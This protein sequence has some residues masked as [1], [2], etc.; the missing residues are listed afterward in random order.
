MAEV[1]R[2]SVLGSRLNSAAQHLGH[3]Q[4]EPQ[5]H[6][7]QRHGAEQIDVACGEPRQRLDRRQPHHGQQG[8][9]DDADDH[10]LAVISSE[11]FMPSQRKGK[12]PGMEDQS[13]S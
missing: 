8:A 1:R 6:H 12:A 13:N 11:I 3:D 7:H 4:E 9:P 2:K 5:Q 10:G